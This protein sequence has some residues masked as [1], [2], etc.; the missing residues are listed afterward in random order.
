M[1]RLKPLSWM[2]LLIV[3]VGSAVELLPAQVT[4]D[5][6]IRALD[7][8][9]ES[10]Q[11]TDKTGKFTIQASYLSCDSGTVNLKKEDGK[12]LAVPLNRLS[13]TDQAYV[14][15]QILAA[16]EAAKSQKEDKPE[17]IE[18]RKPAGPPANDRGLGILPLDP[19][20]VYIHVEG[21]PVPTAEQA[22]RSRYTD[23]DKD[24]TPLVEAEKAR[25]AKAGELHLEWE[26]QLGYNLVRVETHHMLLH[27]Q[28]PAAKAKQVGMALEAMKLHLQKL[29][30]SMLLTPTRP[31]KDEIVIVLG[32]DMYTRL[33]G[34]IEKKHPNSLGKNWHLMK[35]VSAG[36]VE[37]TSFFY[38]IN[39]AN[40]VPPAHMAVFQTASRSIRRATNYRAPAWFNEGFSAYCENAVLK[41]NLVHSIAYQNKDLKLSPD[42]AVAAR[43][44]AAANRLKPWNNIIQVELRD[45]EIEHHVQSYAM[46]AWLI[47][48]DPQKFQELTLEFA[49]G[50][51]SQEALEKVYGQ[52][53]E[54]IQNAWLAWLTGR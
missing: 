49:Q 28:L 10:R 30:G 20:R 29:T 43:Q 24:S 33:L 21:E 8:A 14:R 34:V 5:P 1:L 17:R 47:Q 26:K 53:L 35:S 2:L 52:P 40:S 45:Y 7:A 54:K 9:K 36:T 25:L 16:R 27:A 31:E 42:W 51:G 22:V 48:S 37:Q 13:T 46:V 44:L 39:G 23:P 19:P 15:K 38:Y 41:R 11:W 32:K 3:G 6:A 4:A 18:K 12:R 50:K